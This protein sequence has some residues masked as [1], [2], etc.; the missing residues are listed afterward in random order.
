MTVTLAR[1]LATLH[2]EDDDLV[3]LH[4]RV[5]YFYYY[6]CTFYGGCANLDSAV[7]IYEQHLVKLNS[8]ACLY[9]LDVMYEELL[10]FLGLELLNLTKCCS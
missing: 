4:Q 5:H 6:F 8:L 7:G 9:I 2:L 3:T 10:A 1:V